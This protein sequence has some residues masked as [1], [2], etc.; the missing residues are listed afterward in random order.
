MKRTLSC[1]FV[2]DQICCCCYVLP[3]ANGGLLPS[4]AQLYDAIT[5]MVA[6]LTDPY[7][8]FLEPS[9]FRRAIRRPLPSEQVYLRA[10][11]VGEARSCTNQRT[12]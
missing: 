4:K 8:Q 1:S 9:A 3:Q 6:A 12:M 5:Y 11:Y 2:I 10:Q 7:T